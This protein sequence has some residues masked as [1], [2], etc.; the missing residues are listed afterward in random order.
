[1]KFL[2]SP[3]QIKKLYIANGASGC[4]ASN[5][6]TVDGMK[7]G[8]LYREEPSNSSFPDSGW[9]FFSGDENEE[10][11]DN[12]DNFN[13]FDLNTICNYDTSIIP[14]LDSNIGCAFFWENGMWNI[15]SI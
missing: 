12:P 10:Y 5:R 4:I 6:I 9:R 3:N 2:L 14:L 15:E 7:V 1:M 13:I 8:Y 11:T